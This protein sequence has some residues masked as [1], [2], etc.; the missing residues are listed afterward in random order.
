MS[1]ELLTSQN[2]GVDRSI[3][4]RIPLYMCSNIIDP[5]TVAF[6]YPGPNLFPQSGGRRGTQL[7][8]LGYFEDSGE[9]CPIF[10]IFRSYDENI[11]DGAHPPRQPYHHLR[12]DLKTAVRQVDIQ[13]QTLFTSSNIESPGQDAGPQ[14]PK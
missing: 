8:D 12:I 9:F 3:D 14:P 2:L 1:F 5:D 10:N 6:W 11:K 13:R 4:S 7:G